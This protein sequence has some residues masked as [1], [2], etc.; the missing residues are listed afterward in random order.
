MHV[1]AQMMG[2]SALV[3]ALEANLGA[4]MQSFG[5]G[6]EGGE[7]YTD[8]E[9]EGFITGQEGLNGIVSTHLFDQSSAYATAKIETVRQYFRARHVNEM[10]W[11]VGHNCQPPE[12]GT[13]LEQQGFSRL[14]EETIG[15]ALPVASVQGKQEEIADL[16]ICEIKDLAGLELIKRQEIEGF[17]SSEEMAQQYHDM[18]AGVGFGSGTS[19]RHFGGWL[20]GEPVT[21]A[22]LLLHAGVA[23]IY[24]VSTLPAFRRRGIGRALVWHVLAYVRQLG[25]E[26]VVLSST[27]MSERIYRRLGFVEHT[28]IQHYIYSW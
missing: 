1:T 25:Y 27:P 23:G 12:M 2:T 22:S 5:H 16:E 28:R 24:G 7:V 4:E 8:G 18:Y 10:G 14:E 21:A 19:W 26:V 20:N 3:A 17:G 11:S 9:V 13:Y 6:L 15:L